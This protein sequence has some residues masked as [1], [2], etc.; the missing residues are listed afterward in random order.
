MKCPQCQTGMET[1]RENHRYIESG[2]PNVVLENVEKQRCPKCGETSL[3]IVQPL[4]L[5][6]MIAMDIIRQPERL[7]SA[8]I[9]YLRKWMG[10]SGVDFAKRMG[11]D[12]ATVSRWERAEDPQ[13]M[14]PVAERLLRLFVAFYA[15][16][17]N[18]ATWSSC[19]SIRQYFISPAAV[20][21]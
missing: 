3:S 18:C 10:W 15:P 4:K 19:N 13:A 11:V 5:H 17:R 9:K 16:E 21:V 2:L 8:E 7:S 1:R 20:A 6:K 14:G 12:P